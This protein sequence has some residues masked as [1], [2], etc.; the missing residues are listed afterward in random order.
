MRPTRSAQGCFKSLTID[1]SSAKVVKLRSTRARKVIV[2]PDCG[3]G[4]AREEEGN[5]PIRGELRPPLAKHPENPVR[6][7]VPGARGISDG[8]PSAPLKHLVPTPPYSVIYSIS[9]GQ[10]SAPLKR[11]D[12]VSL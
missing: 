1:G 11:H 12:M 9:D 2:E 5:P 8:Q 3:L 4:M 7:D 10:P 6:A